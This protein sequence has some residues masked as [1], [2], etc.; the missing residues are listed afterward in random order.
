MAMNE[1]GVGTVR[2]IGHVR[3]EAEFAMGG[4]GRMQPNQVFI[5]HADRKGVG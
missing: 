4:S 2:G 1:K 3:K 5:T